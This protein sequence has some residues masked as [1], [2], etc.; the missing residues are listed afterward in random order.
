MS[1]RFSKPRIGLFL[2][3]VPVVFAYALL[4][5]VRAVTGFPIP[6]WAFPVALALVGAACYVG[7]GLGTAAR[8][9][10]VGSDE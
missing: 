5:A 10:A 7:A 1:D 9:K 2:V 3:V 4:V 6:M 8:E